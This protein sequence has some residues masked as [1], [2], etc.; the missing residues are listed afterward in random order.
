MMFASRAV[1]RYE[2][3]MISSRTIWFL[4][5][6]M[7][8][9]VALKTMQKA[10]EGNGFEYVT[11]DIVP[12]VS[13]VPPTPTLA[14]N[15]KVICW[16]PSFVPRVT[17]L[18]IFSPGIWFDNQK[19]KWSAYKTNWRDLMMSS[20][21]QV[22]PLS[23]AQETLQHTS[24]FVRPDAD[25]KHFNGGIYGPGKTIHCFPSAP[26]DFDVVLAEPRNIISEWRF[27]IVDKFPV[28]ASSY[29]IDGKP[30]INGYIPKE[31]ESLVKTACALWAP[32]NVF[33]LDIGFD[34]QDY[35]I[36]EANCFNASR[37]YGA[38]SHAIVKAVSQFT[39]LH[40]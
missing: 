8:N 7:K 28:S 26:L 27:F 23:K 3:P 16:G 39:A 22:L 6:N 40:L 14:P 15:D 17:D 4:Q 38:D 13:N 11:K 18:Q 24:Y 5:R 20:D 12:F 37:H 31:A 30:N 34:G 36:I 25:L 10:I 32:A 21:G 33:C 2:K 19:F 35:G 29:R 9:Q 1:K